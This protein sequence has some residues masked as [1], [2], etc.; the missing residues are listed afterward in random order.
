MF[1]TPLKHQLEAKDFLNSK[2]YAILADTMGLGKSGSAIIASDSPVLIICPAYL[3]A[4]WL[5][6]VSKWDIKIDVSIHSYESVASGKAELNFKFCKTV[7]VDEAHYA[8]S[9]SANRTKAL[10]HYIQEHHPDKVFL[11]SG[12]PC[13]NRIPEIY[14]LF[15]LCTYGNAETRK[16]MMPFYNYWDFCE[17]FAWSETKTISGREVVTYSGHRNLPELK[18]LMSTC[19]LRRLKMDT[20]LPEMR[21]INIYLDLDKEV[22]TTEEYE[23]FLRGKKTNHLI[24]RKV[25]NALA[26]A[27]HT[28]KFCQD[29]VDEG[30]ADQVV[31][32][33]DHTD[34]ISEIAKLLKVPYIDG[35]VSMEK[36][37][38]IINSF[39]NGFI[40]YLC[41]TIG[42]G[43]TGLNLTNT[44]VMVFNSF[45]W[46]SGD[47]EQAKKR[48]NRI[49]QDK[50][51]IYY[52]MVAG[53]FDEMMLKVLANKAKVLNEVL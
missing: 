27:P 14:S 2:R 22:V 30:Q 42:T 24:S 5:R 4:N 12:T 41:I 47:F 37:D 7:I 50:D 16:A 25:K 51:C 28:A 35:T 43:S 40:K 46:V 26:K 6:E 53:E 20:D 52:Q 36:R 32:F 44:H 33:C 45:P 38:S 8:K 17:H 49:G 19:Y 39:T 48:T 13:K 9:I 31:I 11:L 18:A 10:H 15:M 21:D 23:D 34:S 29:I 1:N 3:K